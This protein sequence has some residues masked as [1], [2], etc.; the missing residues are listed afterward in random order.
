S[1]GFGFVLMEAAIDGEKAIKAL[2]N[3]IVEGNSIRV[4]VAN[5]AE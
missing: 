1:K 3:T 4:K 5:D 2:N